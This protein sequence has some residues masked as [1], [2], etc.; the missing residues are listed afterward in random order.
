ML[1]KLKTTNLLS[2]EN[3]QFKKLFT[4][5]MTSFC[6]AS[7]DNRY[8]KFCSN[9]LNCVK[10]PVLFYE[11]MNS[12]FDLDIEESSKLKL[13]YK[14]KKKLVT[15][16]KE[17]DFYNEEKQSRAQSISL[18]FIN[19]IFKTIN[20]YEEKYP[21]KNKSLIEAV[22]LKPKF[23]DMFKNLGMDINIKT[24]TSE[25][26]SSKILGK[27]DAITDYYMA[28]VLKPENTQNINENK[29]DRSGSFI[30]IIISGIFITLFLRS[31]ILN[32]PP[33]IMGSIA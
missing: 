32:A 24:E 9:L 10:T 18:F 17:A 16:L 26:L 21:P 13:L 6:G 3:P 19:V 11:V 23:L 25:T 8:L 20:K 22:F 7:K 12:I 1:E 14:N 33:G 15:G 30:F 2:K 4:K 5:H 28:K 29:D 27:E 31:D